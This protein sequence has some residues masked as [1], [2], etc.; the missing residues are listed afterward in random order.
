M[1]IGGQTRR[2]IQPST[3]RVLIW[4]THPYKHATHPLEHHAEALGSAANVYPLAYAEA[5]LC[6]EIVR[7]ACPA[8]LPISVACHDLLHILS[9]SS[10]SSKYMINP[11][12]GTYVGNSLVSE[13]KHKKKQSTHVCIYQPKT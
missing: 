5:Q 10:S 13:K 6:G 12:A 1:M 8:C 3:R 11:Q 2:R 9:S 7:F 4:S